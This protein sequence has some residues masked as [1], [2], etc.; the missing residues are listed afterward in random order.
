MNHVFER[1]KAEMDIAK[2]EQSLAHFR[3][4]A[5]NLGLIE[6]DIST[7]VNI[8]YQYTYALPTGEKITGTMRSYDQSGPFQNLPDMNKI[9][10]E[11]VDNG[12]L[13][14]EYRVSWED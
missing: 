14:D 12:Q 9:E 2:N 8:R 1:V 4:A 6:E 5:K 10:M 13:I 7:I 3:N 11:L